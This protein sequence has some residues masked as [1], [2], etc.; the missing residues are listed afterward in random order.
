MSLKRYFVVFT[1]L[2]IVVFGIGYAVSE[3]FIANS[4]D[5]QEVPIQ[6][7]IKNKTADTQTKKTESNK[8]MTVV[9]MTGVA[10]RSNATDGNWIPVEKGNKLQADDAIR[11]KE[12]ASVILA[13]DDESKIELEEKS[14]LSVTEISETVHKVD[15]A[16]GK[17]DVNYGK[18]KDR[19]LKISS[20]GEDVIA[21]TKAGKFIFQK[22][23]NTVTVATKEG[24]VAFKAHEKEITVSEGMFS[25]VVEGDGP[26]PVKPIPLAVMLRVANPKKAVQEA[27]ITTI[28]GVT[29]I[30]AS[31]SVNNVKAKVNKNGKFKVVV[32]LKLGK[33]N[34]KV[35]ANT[36]WGHAKK[37]LSPI[38]VTNNTKVDSADVRWGKRKKK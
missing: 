11:T 7:P 12:E 9:S 3:I 38:T 23:K 31:V 37:Q 4:N 14:E 24:D 6:L 15:V 2:A 1:L 16:S 8:F 21:S 26:L 22:T 13:A 19:T 33:N 36:P 32:P 10:E 30:G 17:I 20:A 18:S 5:I 25:Q 27:A 35:V 29:D 28:T 34:L